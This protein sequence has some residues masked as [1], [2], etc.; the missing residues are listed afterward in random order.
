MIAPLDVWTIDP[1]DQ[2]NPEVEFKN[3]E[4]ALVTLVALVGR[5][6]LQSGSGVKKIKKEGAKTHAKHFLPEVAATK[7]RSRRHEGL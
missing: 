4:S 7:S 6:L 1:P 3:R 5:A 2:S